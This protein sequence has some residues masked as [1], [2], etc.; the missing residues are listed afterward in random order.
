MS[1]DSENPLLL[2]ILTGSSTSYTYKPEDQIV[3]VKL[4]KHLKN[5]VKSFKIE[6]FLLSIHKQLV[7]ELF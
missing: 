7:K 1:V 2:E 4:L 5:I 3:D 6:F